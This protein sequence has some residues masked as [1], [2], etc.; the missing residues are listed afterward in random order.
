MEHV[1]CKCNVEAISEWQ[2]R[3]GWTQARANSLRKRATRMGYEPGTRVFSEVRK[4]WGVVIHTDERRK[5]GSYWVKFSPTRHGWCH[6]TDL[7]EP[8]ELMAYAWDR[9]QAGQI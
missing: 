9:H 7:W 6:H 4:Q 3:R 2:E 8:G 5:P 1:W